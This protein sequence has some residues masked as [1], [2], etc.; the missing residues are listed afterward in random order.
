MRLSTH[1]KHGLGKKYVDNERL[2]LKTEDMVRSA[3]INGNMPF[4]EVPT[5]PPSMGPRS[6]CRSESPSG[7]EFTLATNQV[8]FAQPERFNLTFINEEGQEETPA[9]HPPRPALA[10]T[11]A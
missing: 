9:V 5:R 8:D 10:R 6:M 11:S 2:W 1:H 4:V 7:S 3:M